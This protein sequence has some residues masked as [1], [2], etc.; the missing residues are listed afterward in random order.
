MDDNRPLPIGKNNKIIGMMKDKLGEKIRTEFV[1]LTAKMYAYRKLDEKFEEKRCNG[2]KKCVV[3][4]TLTFD[5]F[6]IVCLTVKEM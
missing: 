5:D 4:K 2:T 3:T 6:K 1:A